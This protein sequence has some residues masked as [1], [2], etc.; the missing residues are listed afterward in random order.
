M[1][2]TA[3]KLELK[4]KISLEEYL[5][6]T[7]RYLPFELMAVQELVDLPMPKAPPSVIA[8]ANKFK[9]MHK[10]KKSGRGKRGGPDL[11]S[12]INRIIVEVLSRGV[13]MRSVDL[14]PMIESA[15]F[16]R[17]SAGSRLQALMEFGVV[18]Q[19]GDGTWEL[20]NVPNTEKAG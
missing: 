8:L 18:N 7:A 4:I 20:I 10:A 19:N 14:M 13:P 11:K 12:G 1:D 9:A 2:K 17:N 16:S 6:M 5:H 3:V 15:G